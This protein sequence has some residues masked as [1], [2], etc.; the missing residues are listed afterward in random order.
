[1]IAMNLTKDVQA[2]EGKSAMS[3]QNVYDQGLLSRLAV[4]SR[5]VQRRV[6][7]VLLDRIS[8]IDTSDDVW[9]EQLQF[10]PDRGT[11]YTPTSWLALLRLKA[12]LE[13]MDISEKDTFIDFGSGKGRVLFLAAHYAFRMVIGVDLSRALNQIARR[14]IDRNLNRLVC[15]TIQLIT[16]DAEH[17]EIPDTTTVAYFYNPFLG[18]VF[19]KTVDGIR[20]SLERNSREFRLIYAYPVMHDYVVQSRFRL[21]RKEGYTHLYTSQ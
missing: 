18:Q 17:F 8:G 4:I 2:I 11:E 21:V 7:D 14:N 12:I 9:H 15:K 10:S 20:S 19:T 1:M 13:D 3:I 6:G 16:S 5:N